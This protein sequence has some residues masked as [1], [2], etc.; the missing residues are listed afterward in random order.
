MTTATFTLDSLR[1]SR[2]ADVL[3]ENRTLNIS[4]GVFADAFAS[5]GVHLNS[6]EER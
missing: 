2:S 1:G 6:A 3:G 4:G 5:Y